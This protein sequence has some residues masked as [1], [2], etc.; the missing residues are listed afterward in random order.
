MGIKR[1]R[2]ALEDCQHAATLQSFSSSK[3]LLRL[4]RCQFALGSLIGASSTIKDILALE[5]SNTPALQLREKVKSL[6]RHITNFEAARGKKDWGLARLALDKCVQAIEG[7]G[8]EI[9]EEWR[10]K[11]AELELARGNWEGASMAAKYVD[12]SARLLK[13][14]NSFTVM[15]SV[16]TLTRL[17]SM[18]YVDVFNS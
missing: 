3:T 6:E 10:I 7:E 2:P 5:P 1:F 12:F 17:I 11:K 14:S 13:F 8:G 15:P 16:S 9:P 4:A 18:F